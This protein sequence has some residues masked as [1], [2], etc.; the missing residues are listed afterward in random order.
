MT[1]EEIIIN[2]GV[3]RGMIVFINHFC[4]TMPANARFGQTWFAR[5]DPELCWG[6]ET[7]EESSILQ[8]GRECEFPGVIKK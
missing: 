5:A 1:R 7:G 3:R 8:D 4:L 2:P 6:V